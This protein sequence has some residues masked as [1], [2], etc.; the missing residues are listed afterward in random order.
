MKKILHPALFG[1]SLFFVLPMHAQVI[2]N[3]V[4]SEPG[5]GKQE[6]FELYNINT[7]NTPS[8]L[9]AYSVISYFEEGIKK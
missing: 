4:Y 3:E 5:A 7:S 9:D 1:I 6:F 8:S 2:L